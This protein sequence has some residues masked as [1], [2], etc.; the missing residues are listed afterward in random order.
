MAT[1]PDIIA[2]KGP[3]ARSKYRE[4]VKEYGASLVANPVSKAL[5][6]EYCV[7]SQVFADA[8]EQYKATNGKPVYAASNGVETVHPSINAMLQCSKE[9]RMV[10]K[11]L[12]TFIDMDKSKTTRRSELEDL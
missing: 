6:Y 1:I 5:V 4:L 11:A 8:E 7:L 3:V 12:T 2:E 10:T 9:M